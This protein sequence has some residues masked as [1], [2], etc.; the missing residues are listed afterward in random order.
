M[1]GGQAEGFVSW[2]L[3]DLGPDYHLFD[4]LSLGEGAE[5]ID[6][7]LIGPTG[8]FAVSTKGHRGTLRVGPDGA[9][10]MNGRPRPWARDV[11]RQVMRLRSQLEVVTR[12]K[13]PW[14]QAVLAAPQAHI[15]T[16]GPRPRRPAEP[17]RAA[18]GSSTRTT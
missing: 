14:V 13:L 4:N 11:T 17:P 10:T 5:D 7:I 6:H 9:I 15:E 3:T 18:S 1:R 16:P 2:L 8:L 12:T